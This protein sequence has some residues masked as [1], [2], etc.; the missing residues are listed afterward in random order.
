MHL[1]GYVGYLSLIFVANT[2]QIIQFT[3]TI[4][5]GI[6]TFLSFKNHFNLCIF[7][8]N[9][10]VQFLD[11]FLITMPEAL[12]FAESRRQKGHGVTNFGPLE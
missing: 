5:F 12:S 6:S 1:S 2:L 9:N 10:R 4:L 11:L 8:A 7:H 3:Y